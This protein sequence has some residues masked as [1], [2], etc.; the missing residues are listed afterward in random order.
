MYGVQT[1]YC[2]ISDFFVTR[3]RQVYFLKWLNY[4]NIWWKSILTGRGSDLGGWSWSNFRVEHVPANQT[5]S[6]L[7][8]PMSIKREE[9]TKIYAKIRMQKNF[10]RRINFF[11]KKKKLSRFFALLIFLH[12]GMYICNNRINIYSYVHILKKIYDIKTCIKFL[13]SDRKMISKL[14]YKIYF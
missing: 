12:N 14:W 8:S 6:R 10:I 2:L 3:S 9:V 1:K 13:Y 5:I 11:V 7:Q 4:P